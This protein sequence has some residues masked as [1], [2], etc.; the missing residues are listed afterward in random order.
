MI[1]LILYGDGFLKLSVKV[2]Q[3]RVKKVLENAKPEVY[4]R[5][6]VVISDF[7]V[8]AED[9]AKCLGKSAWIINHK[10]YVFKSIKFG[11]DDVRSHRIVY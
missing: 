11:K 6:E 7:T 10:P 5:G 4:L 2:T 9:L 3:P 1:E 8:N